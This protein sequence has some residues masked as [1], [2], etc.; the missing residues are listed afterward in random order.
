MAFLHEHIILPL[1]DLLRGEQVHKYLRVLK[2][3]ENW[4]PAQ[5]EAFQQ[6][7]L[8]MLIT[9]AATEVPFYH[10]WFLNQHL[11]PTTATLNE[12]PI[13]SKAIMRKEGIDRFSAEHFL[14]KKRIHSRSSG[15]TGEPFSFY[16][17]K[18]KLD[19]WR[20]RRCKRETVLFKFCERKPKIHYRASN[21]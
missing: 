20:T 6:E 18:A 17:S 8:R 21:S 7:R 12:L 3:A 11:D 4:T 2:D 9:Y 14:V 16:V 19:K 1:G 15:S 10:D 13:V 5:M